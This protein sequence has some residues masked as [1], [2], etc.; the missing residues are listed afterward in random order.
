MDTEENLVG[1]ELRPRSNSMEYYVALENYCRQAAGERREVIE[2]CAN[3]LSGVQ[4]PRSKRRGDFLQ[5]Q[6]PKMEKYILEGIQE[7]SYQRL[8]A[9]ARKAVFGL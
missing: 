9:E 6:S 3:E 8:W 7:K 4:S 2:M 5:K 1:L